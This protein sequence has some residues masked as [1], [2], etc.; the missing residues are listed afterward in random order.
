MDFSPSHTMVLSALHQLHHGERWPWPF[1]EPL[2]PRWV[3][4]PEEELLAVAE[5]DPQGRLAFLFHPKA[6]IKQAMASLSPQ[7]QGARWAIS[8][9]GKK[10][11]N[12]FGPLCYHTPFELFGALPRQK[13]LRS[14]PDQTWAR[15]NDSSTAR[16]SMPQ[17]FQKL[18]PEAKSFS[19]W[20]LAGNPS[21]FSAFVPQT[22]LLWSED[23]GPFTDG[24][25]HLFLHQLFQAYP[26]SHRCFF[27]KD[28][29]NPLALALGFTLEEQGLLWTDS[30]D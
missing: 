17:L 2:T 3:Y 27:T 10:T 1:E 6:D 11:L 14:R 8:G 23:K 15:D 30:P 5:V 28:S 13:A 26:D 16:D 12:S 19:R 29:E 18:Y 22:L 7:I 24:A 25:Q 21:L 20:S 4:A 9:K